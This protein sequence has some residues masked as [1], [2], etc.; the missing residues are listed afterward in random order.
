MA[1]GCR[2]WQLGTPASYL[3]APRFRPRPRN[4]LKLNYVFRDFFSVSLQSNYETAGFLRTGHDRFHSQFTALSAVRVTG[5]HLI[6][7]KSVF[8]L[9]TK[10]GQKA[11]EFCLHKYTKQQTTRYKCIC[12]II[13]QLIKTFPVFMKDLSPWL[14]RGRKTIFWYSLTE[15]NIFITIKSKRTFT[16]LIL[17]VYLRGTYS[18]VERTFVLSTIYIVCGIQTRRQVGANFYA[19]S[20]VTFWLFKYIINVRHGLVTASVIGYFLLWN[21]S[22]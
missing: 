5:V 2:N 16:K 12:F 22:I 7:L 13:Y 9:S 10:Y 17:R 14:L 19:S 6:Q 4:L 8:K 3:R 20:N 15:E 11:V 18:K 1:T 21:F